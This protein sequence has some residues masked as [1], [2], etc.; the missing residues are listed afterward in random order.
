MS[1]HR[2]ISIGRIK[3]GY[4][5]SLDLNP[6]PNNRFLKCKMARFIYSKHYNVDIGGH[7]FPTLKYELIKKRLIQKH[8]FKESDFVEAEPAA[9]EDI[10]L[11]H[12][13]EYFEKIKFGRMSTADMMRLELPYSKELAK[14]SIICVGGTIKAALLAL[15]DGIGIHI[16]GG[17]HHAYPDHG[18]GFCVFND[19]AVAIRHLQ[20]KGRIKKAVVID[21]DL[22]QGNGTAAIFQSDKDVFTFSIHQ[23]N[24]YPYPKPPSGID[25]GLDDGTSDEEYLDYLKR[26]VPE[27]LSKHK[28]E[29]ILYVAGADPYKGDKLGGLRLTLD[30]LRSRDRF[31]L[32]EARKCGI[33]AAVVLAG[34]YSTDIEDTVTI[35]TNTILEAEKRR[36]VAVL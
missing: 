25:V 21:C 26:D 32:S 13:K 18:E 17:F 8:G 16:G 27:V 10:L 31:V 7:V 1:G 24:N 3:V 28:P 9:D 30:G 15:E 19:I 4:S 34:G 29:F 22:H 11:V 20:K 14:A 36:E 6:V 5:N 35:H 33:P 23:E 12:T 2:S